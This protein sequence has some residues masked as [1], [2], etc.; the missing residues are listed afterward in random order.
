MAKKKKKSYVP[1]GRIKANLRRMSFQRKEYKKKKDTLKVD[2]ALYSCEFCGKLIYE[3][4]S[5]K[6]FQELVTKYPDSEVVR[7]K[8]Q[9][10]HKEPVVDIMSGMTTWDEYIKRLFCAP[11]DM[12]GL[13]PECHSEKSSEEMG[14]RKEAGSLKRKKK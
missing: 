11:E 4:V 8:I 3:G 2:S 10:D 5:E 6:N 1:V 7:D 12:Q 13:C 14:E 9:L